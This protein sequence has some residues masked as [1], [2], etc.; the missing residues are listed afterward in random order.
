MR[1]GG[2]CWQRRWQ[3]SHSYHHHSH[4]QWWQQRWRRWRRWRRGA[5]PAGWP[6]SVRAERARDAA[7]ARCAVGRLPQY[8]HPPTPAFACASPTLLLLFSDGCPRLSSLAGT[9]ASASHRRSNCRPVP[10][11]VDHIRLGPRPDDGALRTA[12]RPSSA[13]AAAAPQRQHQQHTRPHN[14]RLPVLSR[15]VHHIGLCRFAKGCSLCSNEDHR[16]V[17]LH[18]KG[19]GSPAGKKRKLAGTTAPPEFLL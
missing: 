2:W 6:V 15:R 17:V 4:Q 19:V 14:A 1:C 8:A 16:R 9:Y 7:S 13:R 18:V 3:R 5:G 12:P 11:A 10:T